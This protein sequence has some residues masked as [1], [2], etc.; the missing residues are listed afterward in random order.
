[1]KKTEIIEK[2]YFKENKTLTEIAEELKISVS[3]VTKILKQNQNYKIE[4]EKRKKENLSKRRAKQKDMIYGKRKQK[5]GT[6]LSYIALKKS[7]EQA[8]ME[9]SQNRT[10][11]NRALRKWCSSAYTYNS[12][13]KR[14][15]FDAGTGL[16]SIDLP[17]YIKI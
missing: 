15:E 1:M 8:T 16:K 12:K 7:H 9:L 17:K 6:D 3:Y 2:R 14:Y 13:K 11:G 4:K 5:K 10:I